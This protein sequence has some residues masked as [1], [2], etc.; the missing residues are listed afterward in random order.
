MD[1]VG[2]LL[3]TLDQMVN[4]QFESVE[5]KNFLAVPLTFRAPR[6]WQGSA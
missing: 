1:L 3:K 6:R 4:D 2:E 5:F